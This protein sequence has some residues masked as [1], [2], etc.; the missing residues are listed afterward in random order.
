MKESYNVLTKN[1]WG[2]TRASCVK[3]GLSGSGAET[4]DDVRQRALQDARGLPLRSGMSYRAAYPDGKPWLKRRALGGRVDQ[5][6][7]V[8]DGQVVLRI[9]ETRLRG[10]WGFLRGRNNPLDGTVNTPHPSH[11]EHERT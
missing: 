8:F 3:G 6:E 4:A 11:D 5:I 1:R 2:F 10:P 7:V 9:G